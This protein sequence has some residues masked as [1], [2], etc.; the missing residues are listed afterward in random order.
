MLWVLVKSYD[1]LIKNLETFH[2][3]Q[4]VWQ[5]AITGTKNPIT[6]G[7]RISIK[8]SLNWCNLL[9]EYYNQNSRGRNPPFSKPFQGM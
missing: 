4:Q 1:F 6:S 3:V 7:Q 9:S 8:L 5:L 2:L